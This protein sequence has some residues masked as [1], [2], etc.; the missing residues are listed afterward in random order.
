MFFL[1]LESISA[2]KNFGAFFN[3]NLKLV[4]QLIQQILSS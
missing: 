2:W 3:T 4:F 1:E